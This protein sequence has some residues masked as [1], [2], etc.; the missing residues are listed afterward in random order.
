MHRRREGSRKPRCSADDRQSSHLYSSPAQNSAAYLEP[1]DKQ[2]RI[3]IDG[4][5][6]IADISHRR[7]R[8]EREAY[9]DH[10]VA[11]EPVL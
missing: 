1:I 5:V 10:A 4:Q 8:H 2:Q 7:H 3:R 6:A 11:E 9:S